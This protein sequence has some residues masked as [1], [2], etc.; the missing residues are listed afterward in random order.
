MPTYLF[1]VYGLT[2]EIQFSLAIGTVE[3][4]DADQARAAFVAALEGRELP[5]L[6][7]S[8]ADQF[9][10]GLEDR[11]VA[12][13]DAEEREDA[14]DLAEA[15]LDVLRSYLE[16]RSHYE[17]ASFGLR[18]GVLGGFVE[19]ADLRSGGVG[20]F[21]I[22]HFTGV[23]LH[24]DAIDG[25]LASSFSTVAGAAVGASVATQAQRRALVATKLASQALISQDPSTRTVHA[26]TAAEVLLFG[27]K[28]NFKT[29]VLARRAT[30]LVCG[31][32]DGALCGR[33]RDSCVVLT[34]DPAV[35]RGTD[36]LVKIRKLGNADFNWRCSEWH[37]VLDWYAARSQVVHEGQTIPR[38]PASQMVFWLTHRLLP[39][40]LDWF[41][42]NPDDPDLAMSVALAQLPDPP[43][44][45]AEYNARY[46][47]L[48]S[49]GVFNEVT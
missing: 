3:L 16:T 45:Q 37:H 10:T 49:R 4:I 17:M 25:F 23:G 2:A 27:P 47:E 46:L 20:G 44:D 30:F 28:E 9:A 6:L 7:K 18:H 41:A 35:T 12:R 33:D 36:E 31:R 22:G 39:A 40:A 48:A 43:V 1:P 5:E 38:K 26:M 15:A 21:R 13:V 29:Y 8:R 11:V 24:Q 32:Q 19:Y 34:T 14:V 42:E